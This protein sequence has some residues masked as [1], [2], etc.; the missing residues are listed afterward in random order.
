MT[1]LSSYKFVQYKPQI[2]NNAVAN[3]K[4][5]LMAK[6][7]EYSGPQFFWLCVKLKNLSTQHP[8]GEP[9]RNHASATQCRVQ[10][11]GCC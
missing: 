10:G 11:D 3:R 2:A 6:I 9:C 4:N 7:E 1:V 5:K 8:R